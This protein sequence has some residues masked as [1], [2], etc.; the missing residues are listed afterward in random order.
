MNFKIG[1]TYKIVIDIHGKILTFT[2]EIIS[3]DD[4]FITFT[5]KYNKTYTYNK[6]N[7]ISCEEVTNDN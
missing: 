1:S 5:D 7:L 6:N 2:G 4:N 3:E